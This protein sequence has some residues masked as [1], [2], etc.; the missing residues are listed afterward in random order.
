M[1]LEYKMEEQKHYVLM[2]K[3]KIVNTLIFLNDS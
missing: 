3:Y 2:K 1:A